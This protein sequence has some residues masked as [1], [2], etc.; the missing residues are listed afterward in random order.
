MKKLLTVTLVIAFILSMTGISLANYGVH[1]DPAQT[2][3]PYFAEETD[4]CAGCHRAHTAVGERLAFAAGIGETIAESTVPGTSA[5]G[6]CLVCHGTGG[7]LADTDVI[8]GTFKLNRRVPNNPPNPSQDNQTLNAGGFNTVGA[9]A[10][11]SIH[12]IGGVSVTCWG[13]DDTSDL[14]ALRTLDCGHCHDPHGSANYRL[15]VTDGTDSIDSYETGWQ[16][17]GYS[18]DYTMEANAT[19]Y[20][21]QA[22]STDEGISS[23]CWKSDCH[24]Q[25]EAADDAGHTSQGE[26]TTETYDPNTTSYSYQA[27][28]RY[29]HPVNI[30]LANYAADT[31][32]A[33]AKVITTNL[34]LDQDDAPGADDDN[35]QD[36][37]VSCIT[38][39]KGH[40]TENTMSDQA[41]GVPPAGNS[42]FLRM[43]NRGVCQDCHE[44]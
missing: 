35:Q 19:S 21:K 14:D 38:C 30:P 39:H 15:L 28:T 36:D 43:D 18:P 29:R 37:W 13:G 11:T 4:G 24:Y 34:P 1:G 44:K 9:T 23:H 27:K 32:Y 20:Y 33:G 17:S 5:S 26:Y 22:A 6:F 12:K 40:G 8:S 3:S 16:T 7:S 42:T 31:N 25:Y 10:A 2:E 41:A